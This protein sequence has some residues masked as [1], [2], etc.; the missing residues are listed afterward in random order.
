[1]DVSHSPRD[2]PEL[3]VKDRTTSA[4]QLRE[5]LVSGK[6]MRVKAPTPRGRSSVLGRGEPDITPTEMKDFGRT[7]PPQRKL[8]AIHHTMIN[9]FDL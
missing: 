1:M 3:Q 5:N 9:C 8:M 6:R 7:E 2:S 4:V